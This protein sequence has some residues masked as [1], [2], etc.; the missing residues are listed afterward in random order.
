VSK[1]KKRWK[2]RCRVHFGYEHP[3]APQDRTPLARTELIAIAPHSFTPP[4]PI[5]IRE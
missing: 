2:E 1:L 5:A 3:T 4:Y